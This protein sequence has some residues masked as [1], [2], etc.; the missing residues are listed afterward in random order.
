MFRKDRKIMQEYEVIMIP[1]S[2]G[3][4]KEFAIMDT[5]MV[6]EQKYIAVS[7][8]EGDEIQEGLYLYRCAEAEDGDIIAEQI[9]T[10]EEYDKVSAAYVA[11]EEE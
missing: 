11:M 2:D 5:F 4:E 6:E 7:L 3:S 10:P 1:I 8:V 9:G